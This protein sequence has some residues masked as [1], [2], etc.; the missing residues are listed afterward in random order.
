MPAAA[1][2]DEPLENKNLNPLYKRDKVLRFGENLLQ[3]EGAYWDF[4]TRESVEEIMHGL[5]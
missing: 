3:S 4:Y 5:E 2:L 1:G